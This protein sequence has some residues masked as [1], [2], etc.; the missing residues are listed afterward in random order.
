MK[1]QTVNF[2]AGNRTWLLSWIWSVIFLVPAGFQLAAQKTSLEPAVRLT[3]RY[4]NN[5]I[6]LQKVEPL[7]MVLPLTVKEQ[8]LGTEESPRGYFLSYLDE[9]QSMVTRI[10]MDDP[11]VSLMEYE[12]PE[13]PGQIKS[14]TVQHKEVVFSLLL[15]APAQAR[16]IRFARVAAGQETVPLNL[17]KHEDLGT[18]DLSRF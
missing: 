4:A 2:A 1:N 14:Q 15:P 16:F 17:Q 9:R 10:R 7:R 8:V 3:L 5:K 11:T 12:D 18:F 13:N 6:E